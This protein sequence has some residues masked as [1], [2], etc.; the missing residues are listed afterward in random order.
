MDIYIYQWTF[1]YTHIPM[2]IYK[3]PCMDIYIYSPVYTRPLI[4]VGIRIKPNRIRVNGP[5]P[6]SNPD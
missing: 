5:Y 3:Y 6:G 1:I 2:Y 4:R